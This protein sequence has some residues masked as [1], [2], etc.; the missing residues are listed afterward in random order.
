MSGPTGRSPLVNERAN[1]ARE[2]TVEQAVPVDGVRTAA[3]AAIVVGVVLR[4]V[5]AMQRLDQPVWRQSDL[6]AQARGFLT[7]DA[8]PLHP[9][10][11]WRGTSSGIAESEFPLVSWTTSALWR[12]FGTHDQLLRAVP[13]LA[14]LISLWIFLLVARDLLGSLGAAVAVACV[15]VAP[16]S[17]FVGTAVQSD[18]VMLA[19][20][21]VTVF[22]T[23]RWTSDESSWRSLRW[24]A[25][26][27]LS[28][29]VAGLMKPTA[30]HVGLVVAAVITMRR[31][32]RAL[33][34]PC[35]AGVA[36]IGLGVPLA[37][38]LHARTIFQSTGLSLGISNEHHFAGTE[39]ITNP[40]LLRNIAGLQFRWVWGLAL[41]PAAYSVATRMRSDAVRVGLSWLGAAVVMLLVAGRT[42]GDEWAYYYHVVS[43]PPV[44]LL[45]G[46]GLSE[47]HTRLRRTA[48][49]IRRPAALLVTTTLAVV[50]M[51][52]PWLKS[53]IATVRPRTASPLFVCAQTI[54]S[55]LPTGLMLTSGGIRL[56]DAGHDVAHDAP[57]M[58]HWLN[59]Q[60]WTL[61][62]EDQTTKSVEEFA[63]KGATFF[64]AEH[65]AMQEKP[66]FEANLRSRF[67]VV[68]ACPGTATV[69]A[70]A[71]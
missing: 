17:V 52:S 8:N 26:V 3:F 41:I 48:I 64:F 69:F 60:G 37:W 40:A 32:W 38:T 5:G 51:C 42:T 30:L 14:G 11:A 39:L 49:G 35:V 57:Y 13:F 4:V 56:D 21:L 23:I 27:A 65:E 70:L 25:L 67:R 6:W 50:A 31:G 36:A 45:A 62:I 19:A 68:A 44:A 43:V 24:P 61:P 2:A 53:S 18:G 71:S 46:A 33:L 66:G 12:V 1:V 58:F 54:R 10:V 59:R 63:S 47:A 34:R 29:T 28:L 15:A 55:S 7:E 9:R 20:V 16:L 22:A